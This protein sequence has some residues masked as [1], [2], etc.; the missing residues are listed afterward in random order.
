MPLYIQFCFLISTFD[1]FLEKQFSLNYFKKI[2]LKDKKGRL[3][4]ILKIFI[5]RIT[6]FIGINIFYNK[7]I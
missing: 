1:H 7:A 6:Y 2:F 4:K 5:S 3:K